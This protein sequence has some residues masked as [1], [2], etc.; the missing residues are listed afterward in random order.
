MALWRVQT[1]EGERLARGPVDGGPV[2]LLDGHARRA[3]GGGLAGRA[4]RPAR[5][6]PGRSCSRRSRARRCGRRASPTRAS[7]SARNDESKGAHD[8]YD[9]VY[10]AE[11]PELFFKAAPGPRARARAG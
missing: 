1:A 11:R 10:D 5:C 9:L 8:F 6:P 7:R 2:E 3:A 4:G